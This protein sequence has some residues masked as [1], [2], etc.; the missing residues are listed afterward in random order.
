[1]TAPTGAPDIH[2]PTINL[3]LVMVIIWTAGV[4]FRKI[5]QPPVLGELLA[6]IIFG[7]PVLGIIQPDKTLTVLSDLG[8]FFLMFYAGI[9]TNPFDLKRMMTPSFLVGIGGFAVPFVLGYGVCAYIFHLTVLQ[10]LFVGLGLSITAIAVNAR[11]LNDMSLQQYR[12]TPVIIGASIV[13][14][15]LSFALFSAIVSMAA[16]EGNGMNWQGMSW[17]FIK[18]GLF[19]GC[20]I[21][22]G[23]QL[24]PRISRYFASREAKGFTFALIVALIFGLMA[25]FAGLHIILGAYMAGLF[26][27]EGIVNKALFQKINDRFVSITYGFL[28]PIFFVSLSF[29]MTFTIF[30]THFWLLMVLLGVAIVGKIIGAGLGGYLGKLNQRECTLVAFAMNGRGAVELIIASVGIQLGV[31]DDVLFS[32]LVVVAFITTLFPPVS[33]SM[34]LKR[35]GRDELVRLEEPDQTPFW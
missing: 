12:V 29:H 8:V 21:F 16:G 11:V 13:D 1:M 26:V 22:I 6:G 24:Y 4:L 2:N 34:L 28:G 5:K 30:Q 18:V 3:L 20:S 32:I 31:I 10:S 33:L 17:I 25:E 27:R 9:E 7:P 19:F 15:I 23:M 14:D 35:M